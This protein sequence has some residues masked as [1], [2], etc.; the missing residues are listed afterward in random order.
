MPGRGCQ[1]LNTGL[2]TYA[3]QDILLINRIVF[4]PIP[5]FTGDKYNSSAMTNSCHTGRTAGNA[6]MST[7]EWQDRYSVGVDEIDSDHHEIV[8]I[9]NKLDEV[10][11]SGKARDGL[12]SIMGRL[13]DY[14]RDHFR[15]EEALM[16][17]Y[18][19]PETDQHKETHKKFIAE[20]GKIQAAL[21]RGNYAISITLFS[22]LRNW[23]IDHIMVVDRDLGKHINHCKSVIGK[24]M[25]A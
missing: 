19:Y 25:A 15:R 13:V 14:T 3:F 11:S 20:F 6:K 10:M 4:S 1:N 17:Q 7:L 12:P 2:S 18:Q 22:L 9:I 21:V 8:S 5:K 16:A 23:L 24:N